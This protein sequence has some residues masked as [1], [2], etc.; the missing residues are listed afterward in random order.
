MCRKGTEHH[1]PAAPVSQYGL[2]GN[3]RVGGRSGGEAVRSDRAEERSEASTAARPTSA[4]YLESTRK[5]VEEE[6]EGLDRSFEA[7]PDRCRCRFC[8][9]CCVS[10][11][12]KTRQK[13][14]EVVNKKFTSL[15]MWTLTLDPKLFNSPEEA[16]QYVRE[17]RCVSEWIRTLSKQGHLLSDNYFCVVEWQMGEHEGAVRTEMIH[18]HV[19]LDARFI[20]F[21]KAVEAWN[22]FRPAT[23][24]P[25]GESVTAENYKGHAPLFGS[26]S[27]SMPEFEGKEHGASYAT[28][29]LIKHPEK[30]YPDWV[31]KSKGEIKRYTTSKGFW[32]LDGEDQG[33][34]SGGDPDS[35]SEQATEDQKKEHR[36]EPRSIEERTARCGMATVILNVV[37]EVA[38]DGEVTER[39][40]FHS[41]LPRPLAEV[42]Q[43]LGLGDVKGNRIRLSAAEVVGLKGIDPRSMVQVV[44]SGQRG[45]EAAGNGDAAAEP[46]V[47]EQEHCG[48][49]GEAVRVR[50]EEGTE[51]G[52]EAL[53]QRNNGQWPP[54]AQW[55]DE[56]L[57]KRG[58][59]PARLERMHDE[60]RGEVCRDLKRL[61]IDPA[62][63]LPFRKEKGECKEAES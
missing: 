40:V 57:T 61:G 43:H 60:M 41:K 54:S 23:A 10:M 50:F 46:V 31:L 16:Q 17:K 45:E 4:P 59:D 47:H 7:C 63:G 3:R 26:V 11:G 13:L 30:G 49:A 44:G 48:T 24:A 38:D 5:N 28:K 36:H 35:E 9:H 19:L 15:Q 52:R 22:R 58:V 32:K 53:K 56:Q 25:V 18:F 12:L 34:E 62:T 20:P 29:Y 14:T 1:T 39:R 51:L 42:K 27:F 37:E 2:S 6:A 8:S 33:A 55:L 21:G